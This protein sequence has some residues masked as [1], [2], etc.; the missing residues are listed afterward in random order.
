VDKFAHGKRG[1]R[2]ISQEDI[3]KVMRPDC[4]CGCGENC[5]GL[6]KA[7]FRDLARPIITVERSAYAG[8][9]PVQRAIHY[10]SLIKGMLEVV[11][12]TENRTNSTVM[13]NSKLRD[14]I[15]HTDA[16]K[17]CQSGFSLITGVSVRTLQRYVRR[18]KRGEA[19]ESGGGRRMFTESARIQG[20]RVWMDNYVAVHDK[21]PNASRGGRTEVSQ[22]T[23]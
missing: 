22:T 1:E 5:I 3:D 19:R 8:M 15:V 12:R 11:V 10:Q 21:M 4:E 2:I 9:T 6:W 23:G 20:A 16:V 17:L 7:Y 18:V 14:F 13:T